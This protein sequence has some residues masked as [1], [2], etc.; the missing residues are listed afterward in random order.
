MDEN[1]GEWIVRSWESARQ[2]MNLHGSSEYLLVIDE[3]QK[4]SNWS[5]YVKREWDKDSMS[6]LNMKVVL[7]G[8][9]RL[10]LR[11]GLTESLTGRYELIRIGHW[12]YAEMHDAFGFSLDQWMY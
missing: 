2:T 3:I 11:K 7:L 8:S 10:L 6:R 4:I 5:E 1:D 9:S 12:T